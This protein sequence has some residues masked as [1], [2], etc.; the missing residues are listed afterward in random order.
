[1]PTYTNLRLY[2]SIKVTEELKRAYDN[3]DTQ[4]A[5]KL[6]A[7][8]T[9]ALLK[10][11]PYD[12]ALTAG[13]GE[14]GKLPRRWRSFKDLGGCLRRRRRSRSGLEQNATGGAHPR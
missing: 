12:S 8:Y 4:I 1:M 10:K 14:G 11:A 6:L 7:E 5:F 2:A 9:R 3:S 13:I